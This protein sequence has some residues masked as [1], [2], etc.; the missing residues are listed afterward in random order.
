MKKTEADKGIKNE[1][2][3]HRK[4]LHEDIVEFYRVFETS[5]ELWIETESMT[6]G[7]LATLLGK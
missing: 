5:Q 1:I 3:M 2:M 4:L 6:K 7:S